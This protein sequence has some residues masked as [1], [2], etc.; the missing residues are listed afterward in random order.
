MLYSDHGCGYQN[1]N[2]LLSSALLDFS[3]VHRVQIEQKYLERGHTQVEVDSAHSV[4]ERKLKNREIFYPGEYVRVMKEARPSKPY[5]VKELSFD[6]FKKFDEIKHVD[7]IRPG[8][9]TGEP[10][11]HDLRALRYLP[12]GQIEYKVDFSAEYAVLPQRVHLANPQW[13]TSAILEG[14]LVHFYN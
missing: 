5:V 8:R 3:I 11:V 13:T 4:I 7:S 12:T 10:Q 2:S 9:K 1:R 14:N 6:F